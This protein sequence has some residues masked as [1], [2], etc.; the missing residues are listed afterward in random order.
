MAKKK[1]EVV[2]RE[3][4]GADLMTILADGCSSDLF[5]KNKLVDFSYSTGIPVIDYLLGYET[6][7]KDPETK[8]I[9]KK[10]Q[11]LGLQAGS[12][13]ILTGKSQSFKTTIGM[14]IV[15]N[16]AVDPDVNGNVVHYDAEGRLVLQRVKTITQLPDEWFNAEH[17]RY[18]LK[19]GTIGFDRLKKDI[20]EIYESKMKHKD[21]LL[22]DTG[23]V[24]DKNRPIILMPPT[25]VLIDSL[26]H[27][28][29]SED[30][31]DVNDKQFQ[32]S[33]EL[34]NNMVGA[35]TAKTIRG[36]ISDI[37]PMQK[38]AN[39]IVLCVA[40]KTG[41]VST[42]AF[43]APSK[44]FQ[45]GSVS[46]RISGGSAVEYDPSALMS[47]TGYSSNDSRFTKEQDGFD[48]NLVLFE[49]IKC[50]TNQSGNAKT[51]ISVDIVIDKGRDGVDNY[52]TLSLFLKSKGRLKGNN[53]GWKVIKA[54]GTETET[55][56]RWKHIYDDMEK[57]PKLFTEFMQAS[58]EELEKLLSPA[59]NNTGK[60]PMKINNILKE[61]KAS[62]AV[63]E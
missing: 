7:V 28:V 52:R 31:Y 23:E 32:G 25:L 47:F 5:D 62:S 50:S 59:V 14:N 45:Y 56:Y 27:I 42:N 51:G 43:L 15:S 55:R 49:P 40:H 1:I 63:N 3:L 13:N 29:I 10:R 18:A 58:I 33:K 17:P 8:E 24:D 57:D 16:I 19:S 38:E 9:I 37:I 48:G 41:N 20:A 39:I 12:F 30:A 34:R 26:Q 44:Q 21:L 53:A 22:R 36:F 4:E 61:L 54:D 35:I 2:T 46:E 60:K 11:V 6:L